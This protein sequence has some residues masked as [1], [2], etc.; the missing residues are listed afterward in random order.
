MNNVYLI[1]N[2]AHSADP[3]HFHYI[4]DPYLNLYTYGFKS[5]ISTG[6]LHT[7]QSLPNAMNTVIQA[8]HYISP[9]NMHL[10]SCTFPTVPGGFDLP[11][12][13]QQLWHAEEI[14]NRLAFDP[15]L[16]NDSVAA[17]RERLVA[18]CEAEPHVGERVARLIHRYG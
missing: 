13:A 12:V 9:A 15:S 16:S 2:M 10:M 3:H 17:L 4:V 14:F 6:S 7:L 18:C 11:G 5:S 8:P 1:A